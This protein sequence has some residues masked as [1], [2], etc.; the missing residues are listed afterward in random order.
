M[1]S[2]QGDQEIFEYLLSKN[3]KNSSLLAKRSPDYQVYL[4]QSAVFQELLLLLL[5]QCI[6]DLAT[7]QEYLH[8]LHQGLQVFCTPETK[9]EFFSR[10][11]TSSGLTKCLLY[12]LLDRE[13]SDQQ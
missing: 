5:D 10:V 11:Q 6:A 1:G 8:F 3:E 7:C 2:L 4:Q 9:R 12:S 13:P